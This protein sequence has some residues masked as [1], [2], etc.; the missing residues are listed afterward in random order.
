MP[1]YDCD[2]CE[3]TGTYRSYKVA[4]GGGGRTIICNHK[5]S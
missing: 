5:T 4:D 3:D 2:T 1:P